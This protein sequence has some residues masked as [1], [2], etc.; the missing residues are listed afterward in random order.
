MKNNVFS[1][2]TFFVMGVMMC[3]CSGSDDTI[4]DITPQQPGTP[5]T[6]KVILRG[7]LS[8]GITRSQISDAGVATWSNGDKIAVR[9]QKT[10]GS[11]AKADATV[12]AGG[13]TSATFSAELDSPKAGSVQMIYPANLYQET[14]PYYN[15]TTLMTNQKG[16]LADIGQNWNIQTATTTMSISANEATLSAVVQMKSQI[17]LCVFNLMKGANTEIVATGLK[18]SDGTNNYS[19]TPTSETNTLYVA[20]LPATDAEFRFTA[21]TTAEDLI[22]TAVKD[23]NPASIT[24]DDLGRVIASDGK[25]YSVSNGTGAIYSKVFSSQTLAAG[26]FYTSNLSLSVGNGQTL[27]AMIAYVGENTGESNYGYNH[28][29][30]VAMKN[31]GKYKWAKDGVSGSPT[32]T[33][34][35]VYENVENYPAFYYAA[36]YNVPR[37]AGCSSWFLGSDS[38]WGNMQVA[39]NGILDPSVANF[40]TSFRS[41]GGVNISHMTWLSKYESNDCAY[42]YAYVPSWGWGVSHGTD[43]SYDIHQ[44]HYVRPILAF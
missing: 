26:Q 36:N 15:T 24:N 40:A 32:K 25:V 28:G 44:E 5:T 43:Y 16:T 6:G 31:A 33:G 21:T 39:M 12:S 4:E 18:I 9:Y 20:L 37:P 13:N 34:T 35:G 29:L 8:G 3:A 10:D 27:V 11:Y 19:I 1:K 22:F 30:A 41:R 17:S 2:V 14:S 23:F 42:Y 38:Q 7:T